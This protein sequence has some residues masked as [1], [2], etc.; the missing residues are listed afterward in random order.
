MKIQLLR[1]KVEK[2][3]RRKAQNLKRQ[4]EKE[5]QIRDL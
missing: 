2:D 5:Q 4:L 3:D 1:E